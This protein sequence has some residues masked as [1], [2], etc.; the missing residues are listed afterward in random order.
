LRWRF[1]T[2]PGDPAQPREHPE[3]ELAASTWDTKS[4]WNYGGGGTVWDGLSYDPELDLLY[5]PTSNS[6]TYPQ[7]IR[8]PSGGD[9]LYV[10]SVLA[11]SPQTGKL[12]WHYQQT[13]G[14]Q[15]DLGSSSPL[16]LMDREIDGRKRNLLVHAPK[17]G[18]FYVLDRTS[19]E[20]LSAKAFAQVNWNHGVDPK[21]GRPLMNVAAVDYSTG[22]KLIFPSVVGAHSWQKLAY[23][24]ATGLVYIPTTE[25]G[26]LL[27][28]NSADHPYRPGL[29]AAN[30]EVVFAG[31][32]PFL[33][34]GYTPQRRAEMDAAL[35][36]NKLDLRMRA[37]LQ[38]WDPLTQRQVWKSADRNWWDHA[39]ALATAGGLVMQGSTDGA[40]QILD[41]ANGKLL[42]RIETGSS[43]IAAPM[44]YQVNGATYV[45]VMAAWGGG[46]WAVPHA[47]DAS[48]KYGNRGRII[49]FKL[50]GG[51]VPLP[52]VL[53]A[54]A[55]IPAPPAQAADPATIARGARLFGA[56][57]GICHPNMTRS[58]SADLRRMSAATHQLFDTI[59]LDGAYKAKGMPAW[60]DVLTKDDSAAIHAFLIGV[61]QQAY[62][63]EQLANRA[64]TRPVADTG[65][66]KSF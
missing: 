50:G 33:K 66:I 31:F 54:D 48:Y 16:I 63:A 25:A 42:R 47:E 23:S 22:A 15:W 20:L 57:C 5:V 40:L 46:G 29:F 11:I 24:E 39:G 12:V 28:D 18:M 51:A 10:C 21:T 35:K 26:N 55:P 2:V 56:N 3:M 64:G 13:P 27:F 30:V 52:P 60:G 8:S 37:Y 41:A 1:Y 49:A 17:N 45:A 34:A 44:S 6:A 59:V 53:A 4:A 62:E 58:L 19:G 9:N 36:R 7:K 32:Y 43:I 38:A 65:V 14:D 61:Q